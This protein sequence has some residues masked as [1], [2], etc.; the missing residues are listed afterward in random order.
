MALPVTRSLSMD[1]FEAFI[2]R[3]ENRDRQLELIDGQIVEKA[4]PTDEHALIVGIFLSELYLIARKL[5]IGLPGPEHRFRPPDNQRQSRL[6]DISMILDPEVPITTQGQTARVPDVIVE[7]KSPDD[8][9]DEMRRKAT[10][11]IENGCKLVYLVFPRPQ[12][13]EVYRPN[14]PSEMLTAADSL[15]GYEVLPG[16]DLPV[17]RLFPAKRSG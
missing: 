8:T 13:V 17:A 1:E 15:S 6:P 4:M 16:F 11:Y 7:V 10:F 3:P 14:V 12:I 2:A 5:G 9:F